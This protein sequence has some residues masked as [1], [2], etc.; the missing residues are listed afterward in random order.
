MKQFDLQMTVS[1]AISCAAA[2]RFSKAATDPWQTV[3]TREPEVQGEE[4]EY[5][6][7]VPESIQ[8]NVRWTV[9][10][11]M[12]TT[13]AVS[14]VLG[15]RQV[16]VAL[17]FCSDNWFVVSSVFYVCTVRTAF[18]W[19]VSLHPTPIHCV[20]C[21]TLSDTTVLFFCMSTPLGC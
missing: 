14:S 7:P 10:K 13:Y 19:R 3:Y 6:A 16:S 11:L 15:Q 9:E 1:E 18:I 12:S 2:G 8:E 21:S 4:E 20:V 5:S 17:A